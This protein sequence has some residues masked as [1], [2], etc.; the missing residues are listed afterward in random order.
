MWTTKPIGYTEIM[1]FDLNGFRHEVTQF[2]QGK[3]ATVPWP[4]TDSA[5]E[6]YAQF[7]APLESFI[8][9][10]KR[11]RA[12]FLAAG[13]QTAAP[14]RL[15]GSA[16][17]PIKAG[18]AVEFFQAA[19]LVH[20][21]IIDN[22]SSR[23]GFDSVHVNFAKR[24]QAQNL[25]GSSAH[26]GLSSAILLGDF[27]V[28][29]SS[30]IFEKAE[31]ISLEA[32][33]QARSL[34]HSMTAEVAFGQFLDNRA[35]YTPL[36]ADPTAL[37]RNAFAVLLHKS[38]RYSVEVPLLIGATLAGCDDDHRQV[39][40]TVGCPLGEAFQLRDDVLGVFGDPRVTGK[41]SGG[42]LIEGKRTVLIGL[43]LQ[44]A[45]PAQI[46]LL[47]SVLGTQMDATQI[48]TVREIIS[49]S[50]AYAEHDRLIQE[51]EELAYQELERKNLDS[52]LLFA[53]LEELANRTA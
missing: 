12:L 16:S 37:V 13:W 14:Q 36:D 19:A 18:S 6:Q 21:D 25:G 42:D 27:L 51:R 39:L 44:R 23:R 26:Y 43:A 20:D 8:A 30:H 33:A 2:M 5:S 31:A 47:Q 24:H 29:I 11:T 48:D 22:A 9:S 34:F 1:R 40:S 50:G 7:T 4:T 45:T 3:L 52:P 41:P 35:Q 49:D 15:Q 28:S 53:L 17:L 10:G 38:A 46:Q 32:H